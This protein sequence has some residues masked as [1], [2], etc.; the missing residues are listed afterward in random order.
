[1]FTSRF[2]KLSMLASAAAL[3]CASSA[4]S[5][6]DIKADGFGSLYAG[7]TFQKTVNPPG[8]S[9]QGVDFQHFSSIGSDV[10]V[11]L[12]NQF[13][14]AAE[15][16][17][18]GETAPTSNFGNF[19]QWAY[20]NWTPVKDLSIKLGRQR[21]PI[22][23]A[24]EFVNIHAQLPYRNIPQIVYKLAPFSTFDGASVGYGMDLGFAKMNVA[25]FGGSPILDYPASSTFTTE[26]TDMYGARINFEGDGWRARVQASRSDQHIRTTDS[27]GNTTLYLRG[28][29]EYYSLGYRYDKYNIV[30]WG[31]YMM[32][33]GAST[34]TVPTIAG[35][36]AGGKMLDNSSGGYIL[37]GYHLGEWTPRYTFA[38]ADGHNGFTDNTAVEH[39]VGVNYKFSEVVT[40]KID[41]EYYSMANAGPVGGMT[42]TAANTAKNA[43]A[44]YVGVDFYF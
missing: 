39:N 1:M 27:S 20:A 41:Y 17:A 43:S 18:T 14:V 42:V 37:L 25:V 38:V 23:T 19:V 35:T 44:A 22:W 24:S 31:E 12:D 5:A 29:A 8:F 2:Y 4:A 34:N 9:S 21:Y 10:N 30:S 16:M 40:A 33:K 3:A 15:F 36:F 6:V 7:K 11:K 28:T 32:Q 26:F 13:S